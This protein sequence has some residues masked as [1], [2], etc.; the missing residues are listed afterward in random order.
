MRSRETESH[1]RP[2]ATVGGE[3]ARTPLELVRTHPLPE[4]TLP[5]IESYESLVGDRDR[6]LWRWAHHLFPKFTLSC[7][8]DEHVERIRD[9][10]LL[11]LVFVSILDDVAEK[12]H[13]WATFEEA[14]KIPF[15]HRAVDLDRD[16]VDTG[17]LGFATEVWERFSSTLY[18]GPRAAEFEDI[19]EF[20][21]KQICNAMEYSYLANQ[22]V[23]VITESELQTYDSHNMMMYGFAD[24]DLVHS[25]T[26]DRSELST[27]RQV[28]EHAQR[29]VRIGN[30]VSTWE[31]EL[32]EGDFTSGVL[33][34][35]LD[36]DVISADDVRASR[37]EGRSTATEAIRARIRDR[38]IE[39]RFLRQW[40]EELTAARAFEGAFD[41]VDIATY[42]DGIETI[43][44][45]HLASRG[46][47]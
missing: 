32:A 1:T 46:L 33:A 18:D 47:K 36:R 2:N 31:R 11:G 38:G 44:E 21:L 8:P 34:H 17:T 3:R 10:K 20:D 9:T 27:L 37:E 6:F 23:D 19:V 7:V 30:W 15:E 42:I 29:M 22:N 39:D 13:D 4:R 40:N 5:L 41:T 35:A 26:F 43:M 28:V 25:P 45:Y 12:H 16:G 24:I 14:S